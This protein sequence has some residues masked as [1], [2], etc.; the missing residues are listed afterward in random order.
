M[1]SSAVHS[2]TGSS[3][4]KQTSVDKND[5]IL[6]HVHGHCH[7]TSH[8]YST[9]KNTSKNAASGTSK[10]KLACYATAEPSEIAVERVV[11][12]TV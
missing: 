5:E 2:S 12:L 9:H 1:F 7:N 4:P 3:S 6:L 10:K 8:N 11:R